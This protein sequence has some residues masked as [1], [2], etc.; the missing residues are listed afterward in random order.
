MWPP[1]RRWMGGHG[2][3]SHGSRCLHTPAG[4]RGLISSYWPG[5]CGQ[6]CSHS[7]LRYHRVEQ[8]AL[9]L[10]A[11]SVGAGEEPH[12]PPISSGGSRYLGRAD[13]TAPPVATHTP[14]SPGSTTASGPVSLPLATSPAISSPL[15]PGTPPLVPGSTHL[16]NRTVPCSRGL[17]LTACQLCRISS[18]S[19]SS[20]ISPERCGK[21][22]W[23]PRGLGAITSRAAPSPC[24]RRGVVVGEFQAQ[25]LGREGA[26]NRSFAGPAE[27]MRTHCRFRG[28]RS[29]SCALCPEAP[30]EPPF[31]ATVVPTP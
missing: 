14:L 31:K 17:R 16:E 30:R 28:P 1:T 12:R 27:R 3:P 7:P 13:G 9:H 10:P 26:N 6:S 23:D 19:G 24:W 21:P 11:C 15:L 5:P 2:S 4:L 20:M 22:G 18:G 25:C 8:G 29:G